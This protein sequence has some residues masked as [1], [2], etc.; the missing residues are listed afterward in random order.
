[1]GVAIFNRSKR[2]TPPPMPRGDLL[3]ESPPEIPPPAPSRGFKAV[4]QFLPMVAGA[5]AM[6]MMMMSGA[7]GGAGGTGILRGVMGAMMGIS[8]IGMMLTQ[9]GRQNDDQAQELDANRRDYFRYLGQTR[10]KMR[11]A[12][13]AQ[14]KAVAWRHPA[15]DTLWSIVGGRR[16]WE[17][18]ADADD[19]ASV[20]ISV[21]PQQ[22]AQRI[23]PPESKPVEDLE[24]L[25]TGALRRFIRTHRTVPSVPLALSLKGFRHVMLIGDNDAGRGL[26]YA[27]ACQAAAWHAPNDL[28][29]LVCASAQQRDKWEWA[30]WL[31]HLQHPIRRD[32]AGP[33]RMFATDPQ[34]MAQLMD[35]AAAEMDG[36][37]ASHIILF[38]DGVD[39]INADALSTPNTTVTTIEVSNLRERPRRLDPGLAVLEV[40]EESIVLH[41]RQSSGQLARTP[42]GKPDSVPMVYAEMLSRGLAPYK[43]PVVS[44]G[45]DDAVEGEE[46]VVFEPP[47]DYPAMLGTGD[48][49]T[50]DVRQT[51]R[52]RPLH[53]R[54][55]IPFGT[56]E[57]G[58]PV[59]LDIKES[60]L[61]G[62]GPHGLCIG[63]TGSGKSEFLRTLVLGLAMTHSSEQLN[64]V[65]VDFKGGA[66]FLGLDSLPHTSAVITNLE[67]ELTLVDRMQDAIAGEMERRMEV[68]RAA[69]NFKNREDYDEARRNGQDLP[70]MPSLFVVVDEFSELLAARPE[71]IELFIQIGRIGR[72]IGVH[73]LLA[74]QRLEEGKLRGLDTFLSYRIALRTF[75]PS[76]SRVVI[77]VPDAYELPTPPGNG[78]LK[79]DT[80]SMVRFKAAYVSGPWH[81][82]TSSPTEGDE[83]D[84][85]DPT[86]LEPGK[87]TWVPPVL[88]FG[89]EFVPAVLPPEPE[90]AA[91][92]DEDPDDVRPEPAEVEV[93][94]ERDDG[95]EDDEE[96]TLLSIAV[97][98]MVGQGW[99]AHQVWLPP[100]DDPPTMDQLVRSELVVHP[101]RGL[102]TADERLHG[103]LTGPVAL[104]DRPRQ[105]RRDPMWLDYAGSGGN[106]AIVGGPQAGKSTGLRAA[107]TGLSLLHTPEEVG[108]YCLDFGGGTLMGMRNLPHMGSVASRLEVDRVRRTVAELSSL[109][110]QREMAFA[111]LGIDG[112]ASYRRG[113]REG[114]IEKDRFPT[115]VFLVVDNWM[116]LRQEFESQ[117]GPITNLAAR[118]LG[119]GIHVMGSANKWSEFRVAIRDLLQS[120]VE[121]KLGDPFESE[122]DRKVAALVPAG[123]PGRGLSNDKLHMLTGLPRIDGVE[124][125]E[126][127][128]D[129]VK[130]MCKRMTEAWPG[131]KAAEVRMLP[132]NLPFG[133][134]PKISHDGQNRSIP[135]AIDELEL[136]PVEFDPTVD[137]TLAIFGGP[138]SGKST[139]LRTLLNGI[140]T[141]YTPDEAKIVLLDYR[142]ALLGAVETDHM[143]GYAASS[144]AGTKL[145]QDAAASMK[146][147]LPGSDVTQQQ[148]RDRSWW[149]GP[150]LFVVVDDYELV[151]TTTG[152]AMQPFGELV[153]Q[154]RDIGLHIIIARAFGGAG[155]STFSDPVVTR[156]KDAVNPAL[157][158]SGNKDEGPLWRDEKGQPLPTGRGVLVTRA[159]KVLV[160]AAN[161]PPKES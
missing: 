120:R 136:A 79:F 54:L 88:E 151:A 154:A 148:L 5:G 125:A 29:I 48:P 104:V 156:M 53:Q 61:G 84:F 23:T 94:V 63:A 91:P 71:F 123:R 93:E 101:K 119:F 77:G 35:G 10:R 128:S 76:E 132:D 95:G 157:L 108:F 19:F 16:M 89:T 9:T 102:T 75:S 103:R 140:V 24:P 100:L 150:E 66:T 13:D 40:D 133:A 99:P 131:K 110:Q 56:G 114:T 158:M 74:S 97:G 8:M 69:G 144:A 92:R 81:G 62:M 85:A 15:P 130:D 33:V 31:P 41:R 111:Q 21:G 38:V 117:E 107:I 141:R 67:G 28:R 80:V 37:T 113:R 129:G 1:M 127:L 60:A 83:P 50:L 30:K 2:S 45:D 25:T 143:L 73:L 146:K 65:L 44:A 7:M 59:E 57:D 27:M 68:L 124:D 22:F 12:A 90:L 116:T 155:R 126:T 112:M 47:K 82:S 46:E 106:V 147:R 96:E 98:R 36:T 138:E 159:G 3:L 34:D 42:L 134:L 135:W 78:Y 121:L 49:L 43:L 14:R 142:R 32:G 86:S 122:I 149:K 161:L 4:L 152:N 52:L 153:S 118:G 87:K 6:S 72:S 26:A 160:Q 58:R 70:P 145:A 139:I 115:D 105:Q 20:R 64:Y 18:R 55:R 11:Q 137:P 17:R 109:L 51:W 39:G